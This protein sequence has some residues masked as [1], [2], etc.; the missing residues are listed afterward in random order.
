MFHRAKAAPGS[1]LAQARCAAH[2]AFD[3][4]WKGGLMT[5]SEAYAWLAEQ[6]DVAPADCHMVLFDEATCERVVRL[7]DTFM[8]R[9]LMDF[10]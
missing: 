5:R 8:F 1:P 4:I 6:L 2:S 3:A 7:A 10:E 9:Q